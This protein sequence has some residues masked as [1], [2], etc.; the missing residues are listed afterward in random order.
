MPSIRKPEEI[1]A[2]SRTSSETARLAPSRVNVGGQQYRFSTPLTL[3]VWDIGPGGFDAHAQPWRLYTVFVV[4]D[5]LGQPKLIASLESIPSGYSAAR[6]VGYLDTNADAEINGAS[7]VIEGTVGQVRTALLTESQFQAENGV[8]WILADGRDVSGSRFAGLFGSSAVPDL[9]G[10]FLRGKNNDREDS[11]E[12]PDGELN[13][14]AYQAD[15]FASHNHRQTTVAFFGTGNSRASGQSTD[16]NVGS[17]TLNAG[18]NETR[19][20]NATVNYFIKV[21]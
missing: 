1:G 7:N 17:F 8:G 9:R 19:S 21:N 4:V 2:L 16:G 18:G 3:S 6:A 11:K 14:G 12:N 15:M 13:L 5:S 10:L 20:K